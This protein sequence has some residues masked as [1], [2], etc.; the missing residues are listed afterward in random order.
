MSGDSIKD[1]VLRR[2]YLLGNSIKCEMNSEAL[3]F[4]I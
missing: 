4:T 1:I 3:V 2:E